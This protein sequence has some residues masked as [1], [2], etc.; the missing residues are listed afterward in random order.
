LLAEKYFK[1]LKDMKD[2]NLKLKQDCIKQIKDTRK[3]MDNKMVKYLRDYLKKM[4]EE[5]RILKRELR[6]KEQR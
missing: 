6:E 5:D 4:E 1:T 3:E 2:D